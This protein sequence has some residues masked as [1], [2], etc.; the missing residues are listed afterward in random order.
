MPPTETRVCLELLPSGVIG[1]IFGFL[2]HAE[3]MLMFL[4]LPGVA[5]SSADWGPDSLAVLDARQPD[6]ASDEIFLTALDSPPIYQVCGTE[7]R[8]VA[9]G[10]EVS[11]NGLRTM[12][13]L[14]PGTCPN[15]RRICFVERGHAPRGAIAALFCGM[16]LVALEMGEPSKRAVEEIPGRNHLEE[17]AFQSVNH[18][19]LPAVSRCLQRLKRSENK[20]ESLEFSIKAAHRRDRIHLLD[21]FLC[22]LPTNLPATKRLCVFGGGRVMVAFVRSVAVLR[23]AGVSVFGAS[24]ANG[25]MDVVLHGSPEHRFV[26]HGQ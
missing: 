2:S 26:D 4:A 6:S 20:L 1:R 9:L 3:Q 24:G 15:V 14:L 5:R 21:R 16:R 10:E 25:A 7:L 19:S 13:S 8:V 17:M 11:V 22:D 12:I 23:D 18:F